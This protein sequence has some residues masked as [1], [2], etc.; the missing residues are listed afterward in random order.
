MA[1]PK[2]GSRKITVDGNVYRWYIRHKPTYG[3]LLFQEIMT[4]A[5]ER[6]GEHQLGILIVEL[7]RGRPDSGWYTN[8]TP[9]T[10]KNI[11]EYIRTAHEKGWQAD[12]AG[13]PFIL[14]LM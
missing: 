5:I 1:I 10:P 4:V 7:K 11:A 12:R 2:K 8:T 9:V 3:Q 14:K 13:K 6:L